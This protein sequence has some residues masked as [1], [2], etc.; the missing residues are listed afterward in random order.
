V[1]TRSSDFLS[2][3]LADDHA[4]F[5]SEILKALAAENGLRVLA[6]VENGE[7]AFEAIGRHRP[8]VA[9]LDIQMPGWSGLEVARAVRAQ[10][11]ATHI[12]FLTIHADEHIVR[13]AL[14]LGV[15]GYVLKDDFDAELI[16]AIRAVGEKKIY[17][18]SR[19]RHSFGHGYI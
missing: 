1:P 7:Q 16:P 10:G 19:L 8:H 15:L 14:Q 3:V 4:S 5:R 17:L 2:L 6:A 11:L 18:S 13:S 9:V 12:A